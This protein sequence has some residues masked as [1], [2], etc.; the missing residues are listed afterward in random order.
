M[1]IMEQQ[2]TKEE[3]KKRKAREASKRWREKNRTY[4]QQ[5]QRMYA[6]R[7][8]YPMCPFCGK[9][10][11]KMTAKRCIKCHVGESHSAWKGGKWKTTQGYVKVLVPEGTP[12]RNK[13]RY[14][15]EH[16]LVMQNH[17]GREL[18]PGETVHHIN[19]IRDDN[20]IENLELWVSR[21]PAGQR[22][23]QLVQWAKEILATYEKLEDN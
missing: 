2:E 6:K 23:D 11:G 20:R 3:R 18:F 22:V 8:E 1:V 9:K 14:I 13:S 15:L 21:Q 4:H 5:Y 12:G 16:R 10:M 7:I 19:G 17:L